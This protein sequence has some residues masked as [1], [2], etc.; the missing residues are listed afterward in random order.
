M[1][2]PSLGHKY[3]ADHIADVLDWC[4]K[5]GIKHVAAFLCS[6]ENLLN[7]D[8]AEVAYLMEVIERSWP[9]N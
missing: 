4:A 6:T 1:A 3:G 7:R 2:D 5:A 9:T 8:D